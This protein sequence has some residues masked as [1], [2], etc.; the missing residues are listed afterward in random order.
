MES[1][2][3]ETELKIL[4]ILWD[5]G[6]MSAKDIVIKLKESTGWQKST[7]YTVITR[8]IDKGLVG[9][10]RTNFMCSALITREEAK[11]RE[12]KILADKMFGGSRDAL[13]SALLGQNTLTPSRISKL[14]HMA[15]EFAECH[16]IL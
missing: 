3:Y 11:E 1:M 14:R 2:I 8:C 5:E 15:Q 9:R 4:E 13:I 12:V 10:F 6:D 16:E 7:S